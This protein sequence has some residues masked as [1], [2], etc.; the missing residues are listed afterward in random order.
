MSTQGAERLLASVPSE[1]EV[2][3]WLIDAIARAVGVDPQ[4]IDVSETFATYGLNSLDAVTL[5]GDLEVWLGRR[6]SPLLAW[7]YP[8]VEALARHLSGLMAADP[9]KG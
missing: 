9:R 5:T 1:G 6:L 8:T 2:Q 7:D 4:E 3:T